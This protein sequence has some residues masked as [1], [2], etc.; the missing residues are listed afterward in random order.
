MFSS[1]RTPRLVLLAALFILPAATVSP[2][3]TEAAILLNEILADPARDWNL[4]GAV[5]SRD[6]EWVEIINTGPDP[7]NLAGYRLAGPDTVWRYA[8]SGVLNPG[9]VQ[10]VYGSAS[11]AWET[12]NG[13][14]A[15]GLR[16]SN[17]GGEIILFRLDPVPVAVDCRAYTDHEADDDRSV[18]R[19]PDGGPNWLLLDGLNPYTGSA[20]P[21]GSGCNPSPGAL[22]SCPTPVDATTW[23]QV[24]AWREFTPRF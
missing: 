2:P 15:F 7:V 23:S 16:L 19:G 13:Y 20:E 24:K 18:G 22:M 12:A 5:S 3:P 8:F 14:P 11:Y 17:T 21:A 9:Q 10:C 1:T 4:D 6:D